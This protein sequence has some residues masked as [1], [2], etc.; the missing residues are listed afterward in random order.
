MSS[1]ESELEE[2]S[3]LL[4]CAED[5]YDDSSSLIEDLQ[6]SQQISPSHSFDFD[7]TSSFLSSSL[8]SFNQPVIQAVFS[9]PE[10][11]P[12]IQEI[13]D[14]IIFSNT[15][16]VYVNPLLI[17]SQQSNVQLLCNGTKQKPKKKK[18]EHIYLER[19]AEEF[20]T[21]FYDAITSHKRA[22]KNLVK[23]LHDKVCGP[24]KIKPMPRVC[25]R[26]IDRYFRDYAKYSAQ[27]I[28]AIKVEFINLL[29]SDQDFQKE[30]QKLNQ[31][32]NRS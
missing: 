5:N 23:K 27:I 31:S 14:P 24:L 10:I 21:Q 22:P 11:E 18:K 25:Q 8:P 16:P 9:S 26:S 28:P 15:V 1:Y 30:I 4:Q 17:E 29:A 20:K 19:E 32:R 6:T 7:D 13:W 3:V 2:E 12:P